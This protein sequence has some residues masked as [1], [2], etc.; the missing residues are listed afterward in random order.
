MKTINVA[1]LL[2]MQMQTPG[3]Q[4]IKVRFYFQVIKSSRLNIDLIVVKNLL[5]VCQI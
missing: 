5:I 4:H 3:V 1:F 2:A